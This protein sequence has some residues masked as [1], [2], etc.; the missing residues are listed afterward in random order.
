MYKPVDKY[1]YGCFC[2]KIMEGVG[3]VYY[4]LYTKVA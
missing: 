2:T 3:Y 1:S 4:L